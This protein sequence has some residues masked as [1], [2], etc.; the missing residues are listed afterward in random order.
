MKQLRVAICG[1]G[2]GAEH[3]D[4][5]LA[6]PH[7]YQISCVAD[8]D[9]LRA[10]PLV[11][12][13]KSAYVTSYVDALNRDDVDIVDICLPPQL[14]KEA[15]VQAA[16]AG[17][18]VI[19]EKP[20]VPSLSD[21]DEIIVLAKLA[22]IKIMPVFQYRFGNGLSLLRKL[23][24]QDVA[25]TAFTATIETHWNRDANYYAVPWRGKWA[26]ELGGAV[27]S[28]AIHAHDILVHTLGSVAHIQATLA[29]RVNSIEVDDCAGIIFGMDSGALVTSSVT[30]GS[31][32]D[33]SRLRFCF[34]NLTAQSSL[35]PYNPA[36]SPWTFEARNSVVQ[37]GIDDVVNGHE[38]HS[39][40][41]ERQFELAY[42]A[43]TGGSELP[44]TLADARVS[45]ELISSIYR[46][47]RGAGRV[48]LPLSSSSPEYLGWQ[49][50]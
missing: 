34:S 32:S 1:A 38:Y 42:D 21:I 37:A 19:C 50:Q 9:R 28:H 17:K 11:D 41:F 24:E 20:L 22:S 10:K 13:A 7:L 46:S 29:T 25:G 39:E 40:G 43:F 35:T 16:A 2:I 6:L 23:I 5:Y 3:L 31:A 8:P 30:L 47:S 45:L 12:K 26:S 33:Q 44:V 36:T 15:I 48:E 14:H 27:V 4:A 49:P 18:Q